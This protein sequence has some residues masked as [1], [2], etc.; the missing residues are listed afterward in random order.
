MA[1]G[2][3]KT[4]V[5]L[6]AT[7]DAQPNTVLVLVPSLTLLQQTLGEWSKHNAFVPGFR[8]LCVQTKLSA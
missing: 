2:S 1:C 6:W 3:G 7:Q 4:L 8:Y 5:A